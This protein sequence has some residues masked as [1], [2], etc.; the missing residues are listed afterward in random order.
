M[1]RLLYTYRYVNGAPDDLERVLLDR[2]IELLRAATDSPEGE[3]SADGSHLIVLQS[4]VAGHEVAKQV[5]V[6]T[7]VA[8]RSGTRVILP[9][10]WH[11]DPG[12]HAFPTFRGSIELEPL[13][14]R[15]AQ[16]CLVGSYTAPLGPLGTIADTIMLGGVGQMTADA[17]L[18]R[19]AEE[20]GRVVGSPPVATPRNA[21]PPKAPGTAL[22]VRDVMTANPIVIDQDLPLRTAALLLFH[23]GISGAPVVTAEGELTGVLSEADLLVKE[24]RWRFGVGRRS[25]EEDRRRDARTVAEACTRP[26]R[27]TSPDAQLTEVV[28]TMLDEDVNRLVVVGE[29]RIAGIISRHDVLR[30]MIRDDADTELAV[31][32]VVEANGGEDVD[33]AVEWGE[34]TLSGTT[35]LRSVAERLPRLV[36]AVNGVMSVAGEVA[37]KVDDK[38]PLSAHV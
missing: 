23:A 35:T 25:R 36:G 32:S 9:I 17:I 13:D 26:A 15:S 12:M 22:R 38:M 10:T 30:A 5:R 29:G 34:V 14:A 1:Q 16:L 33:V 2:A 3:P 28:R 21:T 6:T 4:T 18:G 8:H 27:T 19:L 37:W 24:A 11:A 20:L 7:G 31:R